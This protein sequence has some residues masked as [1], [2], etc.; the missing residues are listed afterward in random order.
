[1]DIEEKIKIIKS[2]AEKYNLTKYGLRR[3]FDTSF[4]ESVEEWVRDN[5][6]TDLQETAI[7]NIIEKF[8]IKV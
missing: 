8:K 1:M 6:P 4:V 2:W 3:P 5:E 7:D